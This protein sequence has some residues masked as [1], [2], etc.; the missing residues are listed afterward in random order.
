MSLSMT[1]TASPRRP[2]IEAYWTKNATSSHPTYTI[3][4]KPTSQKPSAG[5]LS[6]RSRNSVSEQ[7]SASARSCVMSVPLY[8]TLACRP[9]QVAPRCGNGERHRVL[10]SHGD[11]H[12][13]DTILNRAFPNLLGSSRQEAGSATM[14]GSFPVRLRKQTKNLSKNERRQGDVMKKIRLETYAMH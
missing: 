2:P 13:S 6:R 5:L 8:Q 11:L 7:P 10:P 9:P 12:R 4:K 3:S 14:S 1:S